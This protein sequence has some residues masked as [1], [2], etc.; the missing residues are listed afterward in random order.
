MH[1]LPRQSIHLSIYR[2]T[3]LPTYLRPPTHPSCRRHA[4]HQLAAREISHGHIDREVLNRG[5]V[6]GAEQREERRCEDDGA[7][8]Q[9][10]GD[11]HDVRDVGDDVGVVWGAGALAV[12]CVCGFM[13]EGIR[14]GA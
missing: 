7:G 4:A 6:V 1:P 10:V 3:Y 14:T 5:L 9:P 13:G 2:P 12:E 8:C 11:L